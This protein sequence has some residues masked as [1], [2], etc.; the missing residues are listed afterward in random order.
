MGVRGSYTQ[1][2]FPT[3]MMFHS[4]YKELLD[5]N[6]SIY[7]EGA[8]LYE[9]DDDS[10]QAKAARKE[11]HLELLRELIRDNI[12]YDGL[13]RDYP[14]R[15]R[16]IANYVEMMAQACCSDR[17]EIRINQQDFPQVCVCSAFEKP[18]ADQPADK[19]VRG[20]GR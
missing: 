2:G 3:E 16:E 12:D 18:G 17:R 20:T 10:D 15:R 19:R 7:P 1:I 9:E 14:N 5:Y 4:K 6:Q 13:M 11:E 8:A